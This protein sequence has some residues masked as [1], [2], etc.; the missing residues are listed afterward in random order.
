MDAA[1]LLDLNSQGFAS[2]LATGCCTKWEGTKTLKY[3]RVFRGSGLVVVRV[4]ETEKGCVV[5][6]FAFCAPL[7]LSKKA[8][9][10]QFPDEQRNSKHWSPEPHVIFSGFSCSVAGTLWSPSKCGDWLTPGGR[11]PVGPRRYHKTVF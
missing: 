6:W 10:S 5:P 8:P 11:P 7:L 9:H 1:V 2:S 4:F 3:V